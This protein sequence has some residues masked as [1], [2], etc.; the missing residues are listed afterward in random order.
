MNALLAQLSDHFER[1]RRVHISRSPKAWLTAGHRGILDASKSGDR[2]LSARL[3]AEHLSATAFDVMELLE[4]GYD[5]ARL[6]QTLED[7]GAR[8]KRKR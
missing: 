3:L 5:G 6:R 1:Y 8:P 7:V 2:E 4:P